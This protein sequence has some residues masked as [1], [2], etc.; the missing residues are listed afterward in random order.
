MLKINRLLM[1]MFCLVFTI[2]IVLSGC[3]KSNNT[4]NDTGSN[5]GNKA[6]SSNPSAEAAAPAA[7]APDY[8]PEKITGKVIHYIVNQEDRSYVRKLI[9]DFKKKYPNI[10]VETLEVPYENFDTKLQ[11]LVASSASPDVTSYYGDGGFMEYYNK[12]IAIDLTSLI[13]KTKFNASE[14]GISEDLMKIYNINNKQYGIPVSA[15]VSLLAFNKDMFD[16]AGIPYPTSDYED[17]SW[18]F[19]K[20][21]DIAK[22]LT[23]ES[24]NMEETQYGLWW[25]WAE[26]DMI[27]LY[28]GAK[29]YSDDTWT[30]GGH[31]TKVFFDSPEF[32]K[33]TQKRNDLIY[34]DKCE[35]SL[36]MQKA[37]SG[38]GAGDNSS[39]GDPFAAGKV[40]MDVTGAWT[41]SGAQDFP[42][43]IGV[44]AVPVG[45]NDKVRDVLYVDPL[46][47]LKGSKNQDSAFEWIKFLVSKEAQE[48][49]IE[50]SGNPPANKFAFDKY[51]NSLP[52]VDPK[53]MKNIVEGGIKYG[54]E[55]YNH[56]IANYSQINDILRNEFAPM[57]NNNTPAEQVCK[58]AQKKITELLDKLNK[59]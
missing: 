15:Y 11:T 10:S 23:K 34:V 16:K 22:K 59:Q 31:P 52:G 25:Y 41:L 48:K 24:K 29:A 36:A 4:G 19:E 3:G 32:I 7:P 8:N 53:E 58:A 13:N 21:T 5:T 28:F 37:I 12:G 46:M 40:A 26:R 14:I 56:L 20:C 39:A 18:T 57:E 55:S 49:A 50:L 33:A 17:K 45:P 43:K 51:Y 27:P 1:V 35:A 47:I 6:E 42:F 38:G 54:T 9:P 44:A 2:S 30:N